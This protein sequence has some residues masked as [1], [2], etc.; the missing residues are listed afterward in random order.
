MQGLNDLVRSGKVFY[1][2]VSDTPAWW[3]SAA[4]QYAADHGMAQFVAY[5]GRWNV[6]YVS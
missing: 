4:N 6:M 1:I 5:Q 2:G 3:V